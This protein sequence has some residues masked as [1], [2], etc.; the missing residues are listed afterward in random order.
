[1][2]L[3]FIME[4]QIGHRTY[5]D[6]L[7]AVVEQADDVAASWC[8]VTYEETGGWLE[9]LPLPPGARGSLRG[10]RQVLS[11]A[12]APADA[13][14]FFTQVPAVLGG[15]RA[16]RVPYVI[17]LDDTPILFDRMAVHYG[18]RADRF[19]PTRRFKHL[20]NERTLRDAAF[21]LPFSQWAG[22]SLVDDYGLEPTRID[23]I[24]SGVDL[25]RWRPRTEPRSGPLRVLFVGGD[26]ERK[27]GPTMMDAL[28]RLPLGSWV[29]DIVTRSDVASRDDIAVHREMQP[30]SDE[31]RK[32]FRR[33]DV[34]VMPSRGE[35]FGHVVVEA[36]ASGL[37]AIVS[38]VG[39]MPE[40]VVPG[41]TGFVVRPDDPASIAEHLQRLLDEPATLTAMGMAARSRAEAHFDASVNGGRTL[42]RLRQ[43][44]RR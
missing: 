41:E 14:L 31:L 42:E 8:L 26:F 37:P 18:Q 38:D 19:A 7:R 20:V 4:Q 13:A 35:A 3:T 39:G 6:N 29:A 10:R 12:S 22:R 9:R 21:V 15:R 11:G 28:S 17:V 23:V 40:I 16:R 1:M 32:L 24:P 33:A 43:A 2:R 36:A 5:T 27:G 34:F 25:R 30:N 44:A